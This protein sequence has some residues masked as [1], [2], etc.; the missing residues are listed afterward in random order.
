MSIPQ[1]LEGED[2]ATALRDCD[3]PMLVTMMHSASG[4]LFVGAA[5]VEVVLGTHSD[6]GD[7]RLKA[8]PGAFLE[9]VLRELEVRHGH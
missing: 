7:V 5:G 6:S 8:T 2:V 9:L 3:Q 4:A 1:L